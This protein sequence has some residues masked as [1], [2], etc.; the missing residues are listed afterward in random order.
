MYMASKVTC[1]VV[2][3]V[4]KK[5]AMACSMRLCIKSWALLCE[6]RMI[7]IIVHSILTSGLTAGYT[8]SRA[9]VLTGV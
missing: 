2:F 3:I 8:Y 6:K 4:N 1:P 9:V 5:Y 7:K